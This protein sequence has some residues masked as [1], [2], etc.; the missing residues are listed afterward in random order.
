M[1]VCVFWCAI[2]RPCPV[3]GALAHSE[4]AVMSPHVPAR[5]RLEH[6]AM[7][8]SV[9]TRKIV[10]YAREGRCQGKL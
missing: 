10:N 9:R 8:T 1:S 4:S 6:L 3:D 2:T 7:G 5:P